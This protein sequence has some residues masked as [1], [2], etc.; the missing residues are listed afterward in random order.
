[1]AE[2]ISYFAIVSDH[3]SR[4]EPAGIVRRIRHEGGQR[5]EAFGRDLEWGPTWLLYSAERGDTQNEF[6]PV[7][8]EEAERIVARI[9]REVRP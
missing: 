3:T 8:E 4:E 7:S 1:M 9:R 2:A 5:D 6:V